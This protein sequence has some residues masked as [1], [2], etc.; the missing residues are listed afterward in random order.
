VVDWCYS[1]VQKEFNPF[2]F[3]LKNEIDNQK[4]SENLPIF[5]KDQ[6]YQSIKDCFDL[7]F[8]EENLEDPLYCHKC[9]GPEDFTKSY[10][11]NRLPYVLILSLKRFKFNKNSHF[12]LKQLI[13]YPLY[14]LELKGKKYDLYG[15]VNHYGGINSGHYTAI[16]KNR[17]KEWILCNDSHISKIEEKKVMHSN[18]YILFYICQESPYKNDYIKFMKSIMNNIIIKEEKD[19]KEAIIKEDLNFFKNEPVITK[20]GEGYVVEENLTDFKVDE[21]YD[22]YKELEKVDELRLDKIK[23][24]FEMEDK[25]EKKEDKGKKDK[26]GNKDVSKEKSENKDE[27]NEKELKK[28]IIN[29]KEEINSDE[30]KEENQEN[31]NDKKEEKDQKEK[32]NP[33]NINKIIDNKKEDKQKEKNHNN[34]DNLTENIEVEQECSRELVKIKFDYG[35]AWINKKNIQKYNSLKQEKDDKNNKNNKNK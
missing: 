19:K 20:Y 32:M 1:F 5:D 28:E 17:K 21:N 27:K 26:D 34:K 35:N 2:N 6:K 11:I 14:D 25:K 15:I 4:I 3:Q 7:F 18:A 12:K 24:K 16:I 33:D 22:I 31:I 13:T 23:K 29:E 10:S 8:Q 9:K 30:K